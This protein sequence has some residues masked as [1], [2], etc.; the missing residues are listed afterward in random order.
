M[1]TAKEPSTAS[2]PPPSFHHKIYPTLRIIAVLVSILQLVTVYSSCSLWARTKPVYATIYFA[3][4]LGERLR[5]LL[6]TNTIP[7]IRE[8][9]YAGRITVLG[10]LVVLCASD[11]W[12]FTTRYRQ[13][14]PSLYGMWTAMKA[15]VGQST[16]AKELGRP[17]HGR[18]DASDPAQPLYWF[19]GFL[20]CLLQVGAAAAVAQGLYDDYAVAL[21]EQKFANDTESTMLTTWWDVLCSKELRG[22]PSLAIMSVAIMGCVQSVN[23]KEEE[24]KIRWLSLLTVVVYCWFV[25]W[26]VF[27]AKD[28]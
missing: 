28:M 27:G 17:Q 20:L 12:R 13:A 24:W 3:A 4:F 5:T 22:Q 2:P 15:S 7:A 19:V 1:T 25:F 23:D 10:V 21:A 9:N 8:G 16:Q 18:E 26:Y 6:G 14:G 11:I